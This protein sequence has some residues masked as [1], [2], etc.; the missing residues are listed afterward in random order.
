M[1]SYGS[2]SGE[3]AMNKIEMKAVDN[4]RRKVTL[5][6]R[7]RRG[8]YWVY[9]LS[10]WLGELKWLIKEEYGVE[11]EI[12]QEHCDCELPQV[13]VN[14]LLVVVGVPGEEGYLYE[15]LKKALDIIA[16]RLVG[17]QEAGGRG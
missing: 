9:T 2:V 17:A 14:D 13:Y 15:S 8:D 6:V 7:G 11:A 16:R 1:F 5:K 4:L 12:V 3:G 10:M